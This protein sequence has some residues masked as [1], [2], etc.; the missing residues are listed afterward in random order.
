M[1]N[2]P[3]VNII[4]IAVASVAGAEISRLLQGNSIAFESSGFH[5]TGV[6]LF[7]S[8]GL[9]V[10]AA[11]ASVLL[12]RSLRR[13]HGVSARVKVPMWVRGRHRR[14]CRGASGVCRSRG[15]RRGLP[16]HPRHDPGGFQGGGSAL[17]PW[18]FL[19]RFLQPPSPL[20]GG[21][22][23]EAFFAPCLVIGSFA[24][25][26]FHRLLAFGFPSAMLVNEGCFALLGMAGDDQRH[27]PGT[28]DR[29]LSYPGDHGQL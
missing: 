2:G 7:A 29:H 4:P 5:I 25:L 21:E 19:P 6:D 24:G 16:L 15:V 26:A 23:R 10:V 1:A 28:A 22:D 17:P 18:P 3:W 12:T 27:P 9:A 11:F 14:L 13:M 8:L 20:V